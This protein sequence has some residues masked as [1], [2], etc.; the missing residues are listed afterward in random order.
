VYKVLF[1]YS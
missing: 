1:F